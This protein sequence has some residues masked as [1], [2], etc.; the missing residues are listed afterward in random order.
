MAVLTRDLAIG[1]LQAIGQPAQAAYSSMATRAATS[2]E[3]SSAS[4]GAYISWTGL[5]Q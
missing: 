5:P 2:D 1:R 3:T 4:L